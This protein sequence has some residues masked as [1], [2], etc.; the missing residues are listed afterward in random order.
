MFT[1]EAGRRQ[2][3]FDGAMCDPNVL[4]TA[5]NDPELATFVELIEVA[6]LAEVFM[7]PGPFTALAPTN[8]AFANLSPGLV[9][10]LLDPTNRD[11]LRDV[12][13]YHVLPGLFLSGDLV[14]GPQETLLEG[15]PVT[16]TITDS[17]ILFNDS[18]VLTPDIL[19]CN[20]V[21]HKI[22]GVLLPPIGKF[23]VRCWCVLS[24]HLLLNSN[25]D[26]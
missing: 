6:G 18:T 7:C 8:Q 1:F 26:L 22:G 16:V 19:A 23:C 20:G 3:Q 14:P 9:E 11:T 24:W 13:L 2:L 12:L 10:F 5:R 21:I 17:E 25:D 4:E 15:Q